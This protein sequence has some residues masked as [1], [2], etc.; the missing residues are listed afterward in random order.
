[1]GR[2]RIRRIGLLTSGYPFDQEFYKP[3]A[4]AAAHVLPE[5][6][7]VIQGGEDCGVVHVRIGQELLL[8]HDRGQLI[9]FGRGDF[10][11]AT[12]GIG[13]A[14]FGGLADLAAGALQLVNFPT[15]KEPIPTCITMG[16]CHTPTAH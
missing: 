4:F 13:I 7:E 12:Q 8:V 10:A 11:Q 3:R 9:L 15:V 1:L 5:R 16:A 14:G 6:I 2:E